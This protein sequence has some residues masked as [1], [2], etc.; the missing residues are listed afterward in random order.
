MGWFGKSIVATA[1]LVPAWLVIHCY[2]ERGV[3]SEVTALCYAI[4]I[5]LGVAIWIFAVPQNSALREN[6]TVHRWLALW[7]VG[8]GLLIGAAIQVLIYQAI[9]ESP[10]PGLPISMTNAAAV[11]V[12]IITPI[13][14]KVLPAYFKKAEWN[15]MTTLGVLLTVAGTALI[16]VYGRKS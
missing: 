7:M 8:V 5:V 2:G 6:F 10:N 12:F 15:A 4:G 1:L 13:L 16:A 14:V 3:K 11:I 9:K